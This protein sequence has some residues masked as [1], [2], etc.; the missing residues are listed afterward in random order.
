MKIPN[1]SERS[2]A[3]RSPVGRFALTALACALGVGGA[4]T[5]DRLVAHRADEPAALFVERAPEGRIV[6]AVADPSPAPF[7]FRAAARKVS[8]S[9]VS[10][11]RYQSVSR[12]MMDDAPTVQETGTGSGV[13]VSADGTIVTNAHVVAGV[14]NGGR[15]M[16]RLA[17]KRSR[18]AKVL[19]A[20][21]RSDLA[22]LKIDAPNLVPIELGASASVEVGQWVL[23][24]G[25]PLGFDN[26][27]SVGVVS[28]LK[29]NLPV[30]GGALIGAIQTDAAINPGNSGGALCDAQGRLIGINSAIAT[31]NQGSIGIG[32][33]IPVDRVKKIAN[34]IVKTGAAQYAG[35][36]IRMSPAP[37]E[38]PQVRAQLA[39]AV[40]TED[41]PVSGVIVVQSGGAAAQAGIQDL[42]VITKIDGQ[43]IASGLEVNSAILDRKAGDRVKV[44]IWSRG[45]SRTVEVT[46]Q[47]LSRTL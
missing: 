13:I 47:D 32:F 5:V 7:D 14:E 45:K 19:G 22:V 35:L 41:L 21:P 31:N 2:A 25:N 43:T 18:P 46:L 33:A 6:P 40:G 42:D 27:V 26:T 16:V 37:L 9:V 17:D 11:D 15:V 44:E 20:D 4:L 12:G 24:V 3:D 1:S 29:R 8:P 39:R 28:S 30:E 38:A 36:G 34:D 10:V 23:A